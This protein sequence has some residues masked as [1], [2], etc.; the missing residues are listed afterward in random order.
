[1]QV[2]MFFFIILNMDQAPLLGQDPLSTP[3]GITIHP[4][5]PIVPWTMI[6]VWIDGQVVPATFGP[7]A[8]VG[9]EQIFFHLY[10]D[11]PQLPSHVFIMRREDQGC[12][13]LQ[14]LSYVLNFSTMT[15]NFLHLL[16]FCSMAIMGSIP[17]LK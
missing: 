1:M 9:P 11:H 17:D 2:R 12:I 10:H 16:E 3:W 14:Y 8:H 5:D 7:A 13:V 6:G 15:C 4:I